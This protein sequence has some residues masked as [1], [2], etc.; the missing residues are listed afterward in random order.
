MPPKI[1][2][3]ASPRYEASPAPHACSFLARQRLSHWLHSAIPRVTPSNPTASRIR[4]HPGARARPPTLR[5]KLPLDHRPQLLRPRPILSLPQRPPAEQPPAD[6]PPQTPPAPAS[7]PA[8][9]CRAS[10]NPARSSRRKPACSRTGADTCGF[11]DRTGRFAESSVFRADRNH[12]R[13]DQT[14]LVGKA[15]LSARRLPRQDLS[16]N[17]HGVLVG[18]SPQGSYTLSAIQIDK[19]RLTKHKLEL[20][21]AA[22][23]PALP[24]RA[25]L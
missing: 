1:L 3:S 10:R 11:A 19:V 18:H 23:R 8:P 9:P 7:T 17:E 24:R 12:R 4:N 2:V 20:E 21:G 5:R 6:Q 14:L 13:R 25:A 15:A 22:L 16:Y